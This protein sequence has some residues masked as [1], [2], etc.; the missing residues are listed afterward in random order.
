MGDFMQLKLYKRNT[1]LLFLIIFLL[2]VTGVILYLNREA[3]I[4]HKEMVFVPL[5]FIMMFVSWFF[6]WYEANADK[7]II[8]KMVMNKQIALARI[9]NGGFN[10]IIRNA[11][12]QKNVLWQLDIDLYDNDMN[13]IKTS[14][15]EK[16]VPSQTSIPQGF[17]YVTYD[18][19]QPE[20]IFVVP[21]AM[22]SMYPD[23]KE[24]VDKY[25]NNKNLNI[26][27]LNAYYNNGIV[28]KTF[29]QSIKEERK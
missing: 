18:P 28:L 8:E 10:R 4:N 5:I 21:N 1:F 27:Y 9:T 6:T 11:R 7:R 15:I 16:L 26:N 23:L 22:I 13:L 24:I 12:L 19:T 3:W 20:K 29:K 2:A 17:V 25:E 14:F